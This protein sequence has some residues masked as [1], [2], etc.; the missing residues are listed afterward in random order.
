MRPFGILLFRPFL[1]VGFVLSQ[2]FELIQVKHLLP[3]SSIEPLDVR[4]LRQLTRLDEIQLAW[5]FGIYG[6]EENLMVE[7]E[8]E[9]TA[10]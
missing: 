2:I 10:N 9:G 6:K 4:M 3:I 8:L 7:G 1:L 5:M